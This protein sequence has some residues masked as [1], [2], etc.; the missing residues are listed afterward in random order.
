MAVSTA[1]THLPDTPSSSDRAIRYFRHC[2]RRGFYGTITINIQ[3]GFVVIFKEERSY[4][5]PQ[6]PQPDTQES[7]GMTG[8]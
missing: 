5:G 3:D 2:L 1:I 8:G 6:I 4:L 7:Q